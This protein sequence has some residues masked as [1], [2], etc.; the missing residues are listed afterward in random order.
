MRSW[1]WRLL[2]MSIERE[3]ARSEALE[4]TRDLGLADLG[5]RGVLPAW[6]LILVHQDRANALEEVVRRHDVLGHA[7]FQRQSLL[8][9]HAALA[10]LHLMKGDL[11]A[12][13]RGAL[14]GGTGLARPVAAL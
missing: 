5:W 7:V 6:R 12:D 2:R 9:V 10:Q 3:L 8:D 11:E 13:G 1:S 14:H 4:V